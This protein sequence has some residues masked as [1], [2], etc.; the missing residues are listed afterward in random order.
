VEDFRHSNLQSKLTKTLKQGNATR[1]N[2]LLTCLKSVDDMFEDIVA[3]LTFR[4]KLGYLKDINRVLLQELILFLSK[5]QSATLLLEQF[6]K[7][8]LHKVVYWRHLLLKHLKPVQAE[9]K[10]LD[11]KVVTPQDSS[12]IIALKVIIRPIFNEKF[13]LQD[14][15]ILATVL[16]PIMKDKLPGMTVDGSQFNHATESLRAKMMS[17]QIYE[18]T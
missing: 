6:K 4:N 17:L 11:G 1:W 14:I 8:T 5:F 7:P 10:N 15:H 13:E 12:T 3:L 9:V 2:P 16:D 18:R